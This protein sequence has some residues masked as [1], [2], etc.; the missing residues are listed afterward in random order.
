MST[1][2]NKAVVRNFLEEFNTIGR[3]TDRI[4]TIIDEFCTPE[5]VN[6]RTTGDLSLGQYKQYLHAMFSAFPDVIFTND[7]MIAEGDKVV[8]RSSWSG[9]HKGE[10]QGILPTGKRVTVAGITICKIAGGKMVEVWALQD[11]M[12]MMQ[13]LGVIPSK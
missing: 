10:L 8:F 13:Q 3:N 6:H 2:E 11:T 1:E 4:N 5:F 12:G 7:D 9:T